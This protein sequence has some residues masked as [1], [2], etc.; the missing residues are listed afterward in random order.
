MNSLMKKALKSAVKELGYSE[1]QIGDLCAREIA[2]VHLSTITE[3]DRLVRGAQRML[4]AGCLEIYTRGFWREIAET[5]AEFI[6]C[7]I[8]DESKNTKST[9][10]RAIP[11]LARLSKDKVVVTDEL[12]DRISGIVPE[13][14]VDAVNGWA[15]K[16][17]DDSFLLEMNWNPVPELLPHSSM[18]FSEN[19]EREEFDEIVVIAAA[20][21]SRDEFRR[22]RSELGLRTSRDTT[23]NGDLVPVW[24]SLQSCSTN[25]ATGEVYDCAHTV[26][27]ICARTPD[28]SARIEKLLKRSIFDV[29]M[30]CVGEDV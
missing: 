4:L 23:G 13:W 14:K 20:S 16:A 12:L 7:A 29:Q 30:V 3:A 19:G 6:E 17:I 11:M 28:E 10:T 5:W 2:E 22:L 26:Y 25:R 15:G 18:L 27:T 21:G 24:V 8:D 1:N 9:L